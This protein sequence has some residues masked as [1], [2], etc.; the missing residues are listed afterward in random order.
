MPTIRPHF[1]SISK[2]QPLLQ[3]IQVVLTLSSGSSYHFCPRADNAPDG[4][5]SIHCPQNLQSVSMCGFSK[6]VPIFVS[7][8]LLV[9]TRIAKRASIGSNAT[10]M[11][12]ITIGEN[13]IIGAGAVVTRDVT[14]G[15]IVVGVP[16]RETNQSE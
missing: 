3:S 7:C 13:A 4:Q 8:P 10:I 9:K 11:G 14:P 1:T 6:E 16:A 2:R 5:T 15:T 12:G